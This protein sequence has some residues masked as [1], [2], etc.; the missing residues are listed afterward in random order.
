MK[1]KII[2]GLCFLFFFA[3]TSTKAQTIIKED[4]NKNNEIQSTYKIE[5]N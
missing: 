3:T 1:T 5:E 2:C 4:T